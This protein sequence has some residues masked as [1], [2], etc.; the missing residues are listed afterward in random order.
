MHELAV[1][2]RGR[3]YCPYSKFAVGCCILGANG[4]FYTGCNVEKAVCSLCA[5]QTA[6]AK[7][8]EDG[9]RQIKEVYV[10]TE[11]SGDQLAAPCGYCRQYI[12]EFSH[13]DVS[14]FISELTQNP[15]GKHHQRIR[16]HIHLRLHLPYVLRAS[17][18]GL[19]L[20]LIAINLIMNTL[21]I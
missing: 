7:M 19:P 18:F 1:S 15:F 16:S 12:K 6:I 13:N 9:C 8:V 4:K 2:S 20:A 5:E 14:L 17:K 21:Y 10:V 11:L 3:A